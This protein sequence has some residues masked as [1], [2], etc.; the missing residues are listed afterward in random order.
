MDFNARIQK[1]HKWQVFQREGHFTWGGNTARG[2]DGRYH[3]LAA[4]W[5]KATSAGGWLTHSVIVH[6][7]AE[8]PEGPFRLVGEI[9]ALKGQDWARH[10]VHNPTVVPVAGGFALFYIGAHWGDDDGDA[11]A[12]DSSLTASR[13]RIRFNQR[14]GVATAP[15]PAGPWTPCPHN[16]ILHPRADHWDWTFTTNPSVCIRPDGKVLMV[17]KSTRSE[18][19]PLLL[20][21]AVADSVDGPYER[22]GREP[23]F[24]HNIEDP[25]VWHEDGRYWMLTKDMTG[26]VCGTRGAGIL[27]TSGDG[28]DW[29]VADTPLAYLLQVEWADG[30]VLPVARLE[31]PQLLIEDGKPTCFYAAIGDHHNWSGNLAHLLR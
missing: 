8:R 28:I 15:D 12:Q 24:E 20:G 18:S 16:P 27:Y 30:T 11:A 26:D 21:V 7:V 14:I 29:R 23:L 1:P 4:T 9:D 31:R 17:Y 10:M 6:A 22:I 2:R 13:Q 19:D 3:L 5:P 25:F